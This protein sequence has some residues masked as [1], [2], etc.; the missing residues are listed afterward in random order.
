MSGA[1]AVIIGRSRIVG[2]P[3]AELLKWYHC[4][5]TICHSKT[6]NLSEVVSLIVIYIKLKTH[7]FA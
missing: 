3:I 4:T 6:K 2:T 5:V 1:N 7:Y